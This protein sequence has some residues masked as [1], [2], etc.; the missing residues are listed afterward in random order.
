MLADPAERVTT[1]A[2]V[3]ESVLPAAISL[4]D[5][6]MLF[7]IADFSQVAVIGHLGPVPEQL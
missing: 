3:A 7:R 5:L 4:R 2:C 6:N 1:F